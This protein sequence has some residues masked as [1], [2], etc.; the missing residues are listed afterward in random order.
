MY[1]KFQYSIAKN[2]QDTLAEA[3]SSNLSYKMDDQRFHSK[4]RARQ[5]RQLH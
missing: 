4:D 2:A 5:I 3:Y 1:E